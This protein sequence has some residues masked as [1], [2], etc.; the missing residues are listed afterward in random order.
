MQSQ[1][2]AWG[3]IVL[4]VLLLLPKLGINQLG[5]LS[6]GLASWAVPIIILL[7]GIIGLIKVYSK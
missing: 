3:V 5:D 2:Y 7:I 6:S 4:G 1:L